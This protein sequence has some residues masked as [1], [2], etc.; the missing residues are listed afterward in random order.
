MKRRLFCQLTATT[1]GGLLM[2]PNFLSS[3]VMKLSAYNSSDNVLVFIQLN[4]GNDGLNTFI[5]FNDDLYYANRPQIAIAKNKVINGSN[6]LGFHPALKDLSAISQAGHLSII[7]NVGYPNPNRSHFRSQEIWQT[8]ADSNQYLNDGWLGRFLEIQCKDEVPPAVNVDTID[9]LALKSTTINSFTV[10]DFNRLKQQHSTDA[11]YQ[12]SDNPQLDFVRKL[13]YASLEG[14]EEIQKALQNAPS[15][16]T[17]YANNPLSRNLNWIAKLIK[18]QLSSKVYYTSLN[19]FDT[20]NNQLNIHY[21]QLSIL[22]DAVFSFYNDL[23]QHNLLNRVTLVVFSEFG[24]RVKEN[25]LGTDHGAAGPV[26][27]IGGNN[28]ARIIGDNPNLKVLDNG[29]LMHQIDFRS[30]YATLLQHKFA[31]NPRLINIS[32]NP[33]NDLF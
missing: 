21:K 11:S 19:G 8:A 4:G 27:V 23:K 32:Q 3:S 30:V 24:R 22:N 29:D 26:M 12:L 28:K 18:G 9:N 17:N 10:K 31:F 13:A 7:Q 25:G 15:H 5:P 33:L 20:H 14:T 2:L 6:G 1:T 16:N